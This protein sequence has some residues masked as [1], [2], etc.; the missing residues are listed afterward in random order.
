VWSSRLRR[1]VPI[2]NTNSWNTTGTSAM[3]SGNGALVNHSFSI[4]G[5]YTVKVTAVNQHNKSASATA[6]VH[7]NAYPPLAAPRLYNSN[8]HH[9]LGQ[10]FTS[11]WT[12]DDPN[13]DNGPHG[14]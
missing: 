6:T 9:L 4:A 12:D 14:Q 11:D 5:D 2:R 10:I 8:P 7:V 13:G 1:A 3:A